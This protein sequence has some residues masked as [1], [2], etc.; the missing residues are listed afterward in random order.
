V[1]VVVV[2]YQSSGTVE[3]T[4]APLRQPCLQGLLR[5]VVVDNC[6]TDGTVEILRREASW[7][8]LVE[9]RENVGYGNACNRGGCGP[10]LRTCSS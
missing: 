4:L 6:S 2:T 9:G 3:K 7:L 5:C 10:R 1:T 8:E